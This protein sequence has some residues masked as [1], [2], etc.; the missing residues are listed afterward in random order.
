MGFLDAYNDPDFGGARKA[1]YEEQSRG[2]GKQTSREARDQLRRVAS[3]TPEVTVKVSSYSK[4]ATQVDS[5]LRYISREGNLPLHTSEGD[6]LTGIGAINDVA[7]QWSDDTKSCTTRYDKNGRPRRPRLT[8]N[9]I[10]S[11][12]KGSPDKILSA[13]QD[14]AHN[15]FSNHHW[16]MALHTDTDHPHVHLAVRNLGKDERRLH[17]PKGR[18]HAW[19]ES[20]AACLRERGVAAEATRRDVRGVVKKGESQTLGHTRERLKKRG[21]V[22]DVDKSAMRQADDCR[23]GQ[24]GPEPWRATIEQR[25]D[26]VRGTWRKAIEYER[27]HGSPELASIA[28]DYLKSMPPVETRNDRMVAFIRDRM[29]EQAKGQDGT[30][31]HR[32]QSGNAGDSGPRPLQNDQEQ[33]GRE[34]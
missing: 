12:P 20:F 23:R 2:G 22:P 34:R 30:A 15:E 17:M 8:T 26:E 14:F 32:R 1:K 25:Q 19:R 18:T 6:R 31:D 28:S 11:M 33:D 9:V 10:L 7:E 16:V 27:E 24:S 5:H 13:A 21:E 4:G 29:A 3:H